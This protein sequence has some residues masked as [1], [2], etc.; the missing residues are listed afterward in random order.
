MELIEKIKK[1]QGQR[2]INKL[3]T[4]RQNQYFIGF[5]QAKTIGL[6]YDAT[7]ETNFKAI[8][9]LTEEIKLDGKKVLSMGYVNLPE[10]ENFHI[11]PREFGFFCNKDLNWFKKPEE[12]EVKDFC[13]TTFD[14]LIDLNISDHL[15]IQFILAQSKAHFKLGRYS[16]TNIKYFD[17]LIDISGKKNIDF[18]IEQSM[19]YLRMINKNK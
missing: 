19:H 17:M 8:R 4:N 11:Q 14:I 6:L 7:K 10:L 15:P 2:Q 12:P 13:N 3:I 5:N 16:K 9:K 1:W 18:I